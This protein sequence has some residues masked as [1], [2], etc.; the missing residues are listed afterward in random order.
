ME[1]T[2]QP[3]DAWRVA[4]ELLEEASSLLWTEFPVRLAAAA[5]NPPADSTYGEEGADVVPIRPHVLTPNEEAMAA[6]AT[7]EDVV[8]VAGDLT[9]EDR[10]IVVRKALAALGVAQVP[11]VPEDSIPAFMRMLLRG[12]EW[13]VQ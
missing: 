4:A 13:D 9:N 3:S 7:M 1:E 12:R 10:C 6:N 8:L 2:T 11:D 5:D